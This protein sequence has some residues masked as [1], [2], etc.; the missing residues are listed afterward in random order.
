MKTCIKKSFVVP[1]L[2]AVVGVLVACPSQA[3]FTYTTY[4]GTITITGY[5]DTNSVVDIPD[6]IAGRPLLV[7]VQNIAAFQRPYGHGPIH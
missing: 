3:Q 1:M 6:T 5:T 4:N 2:V 7:G